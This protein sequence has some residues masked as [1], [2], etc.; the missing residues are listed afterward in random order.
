MTNLKNEAIALVAKKLSSFTEFAENFGK[1]RFLVYTS[2]IQAP[3]EKADARDKEVAEMEAIAEALKC[4]I[5]QDG[6]QFSLYFHFDERNPGGFLEIVDAGMP[7]PLA[8]GDN[9]TSHNPDGSTY[10]SP[11]PSAMWN[12][13][14]PGY[15]KPATGVINEIRTMLRTLFETAFREAV[16][17]AKPEILKLAK[18]QVGEQIK[19]VL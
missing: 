4:E 13:P 15:A 14:V 9:G 18:Q 2:E 8:G 7:P 11:T 6:G 12:Q 1:S 3:D 5:K 16:D 19:S 10:N 17:E